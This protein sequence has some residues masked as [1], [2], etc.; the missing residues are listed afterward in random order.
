MK[1]YKT[2]KHHKVNKHDNF[3]DVMRYNANV[4]KPISFWNK[5]LPDWVWLV[6][7]IGFIMIVVVILSR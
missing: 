3:L 2:P 1:I 6:F 5:P 7:V 4:T